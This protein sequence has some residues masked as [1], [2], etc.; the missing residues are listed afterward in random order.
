M[1]NL[2][3]VCAQCSADKLAKM[4]T[5]FHV[6]Q[7]KLIMPVWCFTVQ[8]DP[9]VSSLSVVLG[10]C[11]IV[12]RD[13]ADLMG[14]APP[15]TLNKNG[16]C[17]CLWQSQCHTGHWECKLWKLIFTLIFYL[18]PPGPLSKGFFPFLLLYFIGYK[19]QNRLKVDK[20]VWGPAVGRIVVRP[21]ARGSHITLSKHTQYPQQQQQQPFKQSPGI[22]QNTDK[23]IDS[24]LK[25][26]GGGL[27]PSGSWS[28]TGQ[29]AQAAATQ[30]CK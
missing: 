18:H 26:M 30:V 17:Y 22:L 5:K 24:V 28:P 13:W 25:C 16:K 29:S 2:I 4:Q 19:S 27:S 20:S 1:T 11:G 8:C 6:I 7:V 9:S 10:R 23:K 3:N 21:Q 14:R 15:D 12:D